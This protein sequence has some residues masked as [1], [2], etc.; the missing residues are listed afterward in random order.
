MMMPLELTEQDR[1]DLVSFMQ[2]L[3][4]SPEG[5]APPTLPS[6]VSRL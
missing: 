4:G 2:S 3:T 5:E 6:Q 1:Q